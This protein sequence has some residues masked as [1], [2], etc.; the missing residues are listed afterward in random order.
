MNPV[1]LSNLFTT[2]PSSCHAQS[3]IVSLYDSLWFIQHSY[4]MLTEHL[5]CD[6]S[7]TITVNKS[8]MVFSLIEHM[9]SHWTSKIEMDDM[10]LFLSCEAT[11]AYTKRSGKLSWRSGL[12]ADT[13]RMNGIWLYEDKVEAEKYQVWKPGGER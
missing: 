1:L 10:I 8:H 3:S 11:R 7:W 2:S 12:H 9:G 4:Q 6:M 13:H 5:L